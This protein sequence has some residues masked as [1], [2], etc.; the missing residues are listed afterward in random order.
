VLDRPGAQ[1]ASRRIAGA[2]RGASIIAITTT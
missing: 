1:I 2:L